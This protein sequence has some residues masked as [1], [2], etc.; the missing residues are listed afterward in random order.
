MF[1]CSLCPV[2]EGDNWSF[3]C[4]GRPLYRK[5]CSPGQMQPVHVKM[6][7]MWFMW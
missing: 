7:Q 5:A 2:L 6:R 4:Y 3:S 1:M